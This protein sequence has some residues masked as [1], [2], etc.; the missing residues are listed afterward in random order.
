MTAH[1]SSGS[2]LCGLW[3]RNMDLLASRC[4]KTSYWSV[5][6]RTAGRTAA[7]EGF[8]AM[9]SEFTDCLVWHRFTGGRC[10]FMD[11]R[12]HKLKPVDYEFG[13]VLC[14]VSP[15]VWRCFRKASKITFQRP[16]ARRGDSTVIRDFLFAQNTS[17]GP[18]LNFRLKHHGN[19][20]HMRRLGPCG[21][22]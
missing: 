16:V 15:T 1:R 17:K 3:E 10:L 13:I 2:L 14:D 11:N 20:R 5:W 12:A 4:P 21:N 7:T 18:V 22:T 19:R 9:N 6:C 8:S